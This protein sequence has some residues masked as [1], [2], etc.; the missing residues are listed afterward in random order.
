MS[1]ELGR[2]EQSTQLLARARALIPGGHHL[3]GRPLLSNEPSPLYFTRGQGAHCWDADGHEYVDYIGAYGPCLLGYA[4]PVI[5]AAAI[6]QIRQGSLLSLNHPLHVAF[7]ERLVARFPGAE[8]AAFFKTGSEATTAALRIARARTGRRRVIRCG[9]HG[10]HDWCLPLEPFVPTG[11]DQQVLELDARDP[12]A[13]DRMLSDARG[14][15]AAVI[16]A[17]EMIL[18]TRPEVFQALLAT[19]HRHG[20]VFVLDE[21]KTALRI[22]P[23][24][25][26][27]HIGLVPD[28]T[29]LSKALGNGWP[30]AA[31]VGKREIMSAA[32]GMHLSATYHGETAG[33]AA[34]LAVL[35]FVEREPV[36][37][38]V[39]RLGERLIDGLNESAARHRIPAVAFG[40]PLPP[41]PFLKFSAADS[42][43][44]E[45]L[46]TV[47][48]RHALKNGVLLHPRHLWF[49][50]YAHTDQD[51][52]RT[53]A[54][55][56]DAFRLA[57]SALEN[58]S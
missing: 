11:L 39:W 16:V 44:N 53:L 58:A 38:H 27:Q 17:P 10:W 55:A 26:Q 28:L 31:V 30:V 46:K 29:T 37:E 4:H 42:T 24:S 20:A 19:T 2:Y 57:R 3:S 1:D 6:E 35:D 34:A 14:E 43:A 8:M 9:Y 48:Y 32:A 12:S 13:L 25:F 51:I 56:D 50:S 5:D 21:V 23:G 49:I 47:F 18:P 22:K 33:M 52:D 40:E 54:V 7:A 15:V 36:A 45:R 41:M